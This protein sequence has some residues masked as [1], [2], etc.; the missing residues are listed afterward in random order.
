VKEAKDKQIG[1]TLRDNR[2]LKCCDLVKAGSCKKLIY[3][4]I[5]DSSSVKFYVSSEDLFAFIQAMYLVIG[6][7]GRNQIL[8]ELQRK[9]W[10]ITIECIMLEEMLNS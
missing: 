9:Y 8:K 4:L 3:P 10:N 2:M 6:H 7:E 1:R 5:E